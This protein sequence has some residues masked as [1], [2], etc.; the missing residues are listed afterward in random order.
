[1]NRIKIDPAVEFYDP[2]TNDYDLEK[3]PRCL[4]GWGPPE[5]GCDHHRF[6]HVCCRELGHPGECADD[7][8]GDPCE[9]V[10]RPSD[11][12]AKGRA[13]ANR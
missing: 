5:H 13:E 1:M 8:V 9:R 7:D 12:D 2:Q 4:Y 6:G 10:N 11:W 3:D